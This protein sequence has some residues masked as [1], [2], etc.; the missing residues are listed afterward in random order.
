MFDV[1]KGSAGGVQLGIQFV[2]KQNPQVAK[3][4][5]KLETRVKSLTTQLGNQKKK[6]KEL[7]TSQNAVSKSV[8]KTT[9]SMNKGAKST[10]A[11]GAGMMKVG[12]AFKT[13]LAYGFAGRAIMMVTSAFTQGWMEIIKYD[14]AL[15]N[16]QA[17]TRATETEVAAMGETIKEVAL[18]TKFS[19]AEIGKGM[20]LLSQ[21]GFS[22]AES[23]TAMQSV[24][25][26]A[27]GTLSSMVQ[28]TD[29]LTTSIRA[30]GLE[31][32]E[33]RRVADVMANAVN[34]SKLTIDK[35]RIAFNFVGASASLAGISI[36]ETA[37]S[38]MVLANNGIRA[39]TIGTG[40]RQV[41][42]RLIA[43]NQ[44][45]QDAYTQSGIELD[46]INPRTIGYKEVLLN[47]TK[48]L[49]NSEKKTVDMARAF[50]LF[51]LRGAQAASILVKEFAANKFSEA[52]KKTYDA[53][54]AA[55]MAGIQ[56]TGLEV[57][58]KNLKDVWG[59]LFV[60][61]GDSGVKSAFAE[62]LNGVRGV[63]N[64]FV[65]LA[66]GPITSLITQT[67]MW[68]TGLFA[69]SYA[70]SWA[71]I[72]VK[73]LFIGTAKYAAW[74]AM[75]NPMILITIALGAATA[76]VWKLA[77]ANE[78]SAK[79]YAVASLKTK[80]IITS[81]EVYSAA[82]KSIKEEYDAG[83]DVSEKYIQTLERLKNEYPELTKNIELAID[84]HE[85]NMEAIDG[86]TS[87]QKIKQMEELTKSVIAYGKAIKWS[88][89]WNGLFKDGLDDKPF[90][91]IEPSVG[92][93]VVKGMTRGQKGEVDN[94]L[95]VIMKMFG[96]SGSPGKLL[97][98]A[99]VKGKER[100]S[101]AT[102]SLIKDGIN[103]PDTIKLLKMEAESF[104][105]QITSAIALKD[106]TPKGE[107]FDIREWFKI[108]GL[109]KK[110][111]M[112][113]QDAFFKLYEET[114]K[115]NK[116]LKEAK[117]M[118]N[119]SL[120]DLGE[121]KK[122]EEY[123][124]L[125]GFAD[126]IQLKKLSSM[127]ASYES[128]INAF[129]DR[130]KKRW[131]TR[132]FDAER[133]KKERVIANK[134]VNAMSEEMY[135]GMKQYLGKGEIETAT[136]SI[137]E[138]KLELQAYKQ[139]EEEDKPGVLPKIKERYISL[140]EEVFET[141]GALREYFA[142]HDA[143]PEDYA[144]LDKLEEDVLKSGIAI[145]GLNKKMKNTFGG[146]ND[147]FED[148][149]V[150]GVNDFADILSTIGDSSVDIKEK[151][152]DMASSILEDIAAM[153]LKYSIFNAIMAMAGG[154]GSVGTGGTKGFFA[155]MAQAGL[156]NIG[157]VFAGFGGGA[158]SSGYTSQPLGSGVGGNPYY[159]PST[160]QAS[161]LSSQAMPNT[162]VYNSIT[163]M[164]SQSIFRAM[165]SPAGI[166]A[167]KNNSNI[168][169]KRNMV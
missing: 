143:A 140:K 47:L 14:Q 24:S 137:R 75:Y 104:A 79:S 54:T 37:A 53:G 131:K 109:D 19:T 90:K 41:L 29:L 122:D 128:E 49:Y 155:N 119:A 61:L 116:K 134:T 168:M 15:K 169:T 98:K 97:D 147:Y 9:R 123:E 12:S 25:D 1:A 55:E 35:M 130:E 96:F 159:S 150:G 151:F 92:P 77:H 141:T 156:A 26:L 62:I 148:L 94:A 20:V 2:L 22:A 21:S 51:G 43:P 132:R 146:W 73:A 85:R 135:R 27:T 115:I 152:K 126:P 127:Q 108:K 114:L 33:S 68:T 56:F 133:I 5:K 23:M 32:S 69:L 106:A 117:D 16:L 60:T 167:I 129:M 81:L 66:G 111:D 113:Q 38:M 3:A 34:K 100:L 7:V 74:A 31:A 39:S 145:D 161:S 93:N 142:L 101:L 89:M 48:V 153:I 11:Y 136:K 160:P 91:P 58:I 18:T 162:V 144:F 110:Y 59:V 165:S 63:L 88:A 138:F 84:A 80:S 71:L 99:I 44:K 86:T 118:Q 30:F 164:D 46:K 112:R 52:L 87:D 57:S 6:N 154:Q 50:E 72:G 70:L 157:Q 149:A 17:I 120:K 121:S 65:A 103:H 82:L 36:E 158:D 45:L 64:I 8:D 76:A 42:K 13:L 125:R 78:E 166:Q 102:Q 124:N 67:A 139:L 83:D 105:G 107:T 95:D 40:L 10:Q 28:V 163:G 4:F